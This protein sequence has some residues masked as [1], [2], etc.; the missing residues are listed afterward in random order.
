MFVKCVIINKSNNTYDS[1]FVALWD[2][3]DLGY[4][5]DDF[6]G[7]DTTLSLGYCYNASNTDNV[8]GSAPPAIGRDSSRV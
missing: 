5:G 7:C 1:T 4:A 6:V 2:D 8:Y 3:P